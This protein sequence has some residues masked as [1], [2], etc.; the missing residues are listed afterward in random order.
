MWF[1]TTFPRLPILVIAPCSLVFGSSAKAQDEFDLPS[2]DLFS[3]SVMGIGMGH[4]ALGVGMFSRTTEMGKKDVGVHLVLD[5]P[6]GRLVVPKGSSKGL[7]TQDQELAE[8]V[9]APVERA[10]RRPIPE[11]IVKPALARACVRAAWRAHGMGN[12]DLLDE[13]KS[14]ARTSALLPEARFRMLRDWGQ[15]FRL[16]PTN[17]DPYRLH[18]TNSGGQTLEGRLMWKLDRLVFVDSELSMERVR[19]QQVQLRSRLA[20][21]VL[22]A[23]FDWQR[24]KV[25]LEDP[26]LDEE[27][28][29]EAVLREAE[30]TAILD[31]LTGGWFSS[32]LEDTST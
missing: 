3:S 24:A 15:S 26:S 31:V 25:A 22:R 29:L 10:I 18:E 20:G 7:S 6:L 12:L 9:A 8:P 4:A 14:R 21:E 11:L 13:M 28:T 30:A 19:V 2:D 23:L 1:S 32:W 17:D 5:V 27:E 16:A